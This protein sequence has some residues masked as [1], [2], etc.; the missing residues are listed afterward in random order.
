LED[1]ILKEA[2]MIFEQ[3]EEP[4]SKYQNLKTEKITQQNSKPFLNK[5]KD[6]K[7][8]EYSADKILMPKSDKNAKTLEAT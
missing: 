5:M 6:S 3:D 8:G 4:L 1:D 2:E 7:E